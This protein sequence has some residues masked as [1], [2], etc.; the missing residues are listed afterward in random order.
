MYSAKV[1]FYSSKSFDKTL[2]KVNNCAKLLL[3]EGLDR[4]LL[5][6][7]SLFTTSC[8]NTHLDGCIGAC[9]KKSFRGHVEAAQFREK[10][11]KMLFST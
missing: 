3:D 8:E 11:L 5:S 1:I 2:L 10:R 9:M 6:M 7:S 4:K